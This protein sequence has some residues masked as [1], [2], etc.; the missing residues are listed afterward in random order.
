MTLVFGATEAVADV[1]DRP[2]PV[3]V[4]PGAA[5]QVF[6]AIAGGETVVNELL[7]LVRKDGSRLT[8]AVSAAPVQSRTGTVV[9]AVTTMYE[10]DPTTFTPKY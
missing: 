10:V 4:R 3:K 2:R 9:A 6:R 8:L 7:T 1:P 5:D